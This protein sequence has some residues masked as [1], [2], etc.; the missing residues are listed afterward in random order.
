[1]ARSVELFSLRWTDLKL[2]RPGDGPRI[3]LPRGVGA[4][5]LR[6]LPETKS[7]RTKVADVVI[8]YLCASGLAP[9]LWLE[10]LQQVWPNA[11]PSDPIIRGKDGTRWT[12]TYFRRAHLYEWLHRMRAAGDPFLMAFTDEPGN[13]IAD[14]YYSFGTYRRGGRSTS[15][16]RNSG[17]KAVDPR[18]GL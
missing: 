12:S 3:G 16:K 13:R 15:T 17:T 1:M 11:M 9:G 4:I 8:S 6:L 10:R 2:T 14:K 18:G 7:N 5:E